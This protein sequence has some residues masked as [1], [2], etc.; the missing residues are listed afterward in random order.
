MLGN[1]GH[2]NQYHCHLRI[3]KKMKIIMNRMI[4]FINALLDTIQT[5]T[6]KFRNGTFFSLSTYIYIYKLLYAF[7]TN[8]RY[9]I[10][11]CLIFP[12]RSKQKKQLYNNIICYLNLSKIT[13]WLK[14]YSF[15]FNARS[16]LQKAR[17]KSGGDVQNLYPPHQLTERQGKVNKISSSFLKFHIN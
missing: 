5:H 2:L 16:C 8:R 4:Y 10:W 14:Y 1:I 13:L 9:I 3:V 7:Y 15:K 12:C 17:V 6:L 11:T